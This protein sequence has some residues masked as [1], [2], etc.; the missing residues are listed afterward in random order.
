MIKSKMDKMAAFN[1]KKYLLVFTLSTSSILVLLLKLNRVNLYK[2]VNQKYHTM[3][4]L[5]E[6]ILSRNTVWSYTKE[7]G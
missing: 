2:K 1:K 5:Q 7:S 6:A 3:I 4:L